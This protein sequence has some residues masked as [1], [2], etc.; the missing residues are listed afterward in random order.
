MGEEPKHGWDQAEASS[1]RSPPMSET[2]DVFCS[3]AGGIVASM[4]ASSCTHRVEEG[5]DVSYSW[6]ENV[7]YRNFLL[8]ILSREKED[9]INPGK[10][11]YCLIVTKKAILQL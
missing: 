1:C 4:N 8:L 10:L 9:R 3:A 6:L 7:D 2:R 5:G 11:F